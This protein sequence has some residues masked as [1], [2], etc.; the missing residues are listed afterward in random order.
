[1]KYFKMLGFAAVAAAILIA[2]LGACTASAT[3]LCTETPSEG[4][5]TDIEEF[6]DVLDASVTTSAHL[7]TTGGSTI[8][9]CS[10]G[11]V[12]GEITSEGSTTS[13]VSGHIDKLTWSGCTTT[14]ITLANG[15]LELHHS[16]GTDEG[17]VV[18]SGSKVTIKYLGITCT[19]ETKNTSIGTLT[20]GNPATFDISA[21][22]PEVSENF[23]CP[24]H[25]VWSG[26]YTLTEPS[27]T[28]HVAGG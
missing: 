2:F 28:L 4:H 15:T 3:V 22:I 20:G 23:G 17:I 6:G 9:T 10:G 13:K 5:C 12:K 26:S 14:V 25:G 27:G 21:I 1:M 7:K 16:S 24:A 11:T 18:S 19:Y 8:A